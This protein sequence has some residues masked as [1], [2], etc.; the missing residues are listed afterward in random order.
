MEIQFRSYKEKD[1]ETCWKMMVSTWQYDRYFSSIKNI[2]HLYRL[3]F[4]MYRLHS[5]YLEI[6][7]AVTDATIE[8]SE[9]VGF[10]FG[11]T[12]HPA[13]LKKLQYRY[14]LLKIVLFWIF[15]CY[16]NKK[17]A[18]DVFQ[19]Y[20]R[21]IEFLLGDCDSSDAHMHSFFISDKARGAGVGKLLLAR[22]T[23]HCQHN[24]NS[25]IILVTD[26]DCNYGFYDHCGFERIK[27]KN[28]CLGV[29]QSDATKANSFVFVY[30]KKLEN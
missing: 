30:A 27:E 14:F 3:I 24:Q 22:F 28:G 17:A 20:A 7:I 1:R 4:D 11:E 16:G 2:D 15:G 5:D 13:V 18:R 6:A 23:E 29:P 25:R 19:D 12:K 26:T 21:D 8:A 10:L 9:P